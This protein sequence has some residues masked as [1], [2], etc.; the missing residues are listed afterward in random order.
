MQHTGI[1]IQLANTSVAHLTGL[2][3]DVFVR[4]SELI[5]LADFYVFDMRRYFPMD[6]P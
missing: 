6:L 1:V 2:I 4:V 3:E 5:F